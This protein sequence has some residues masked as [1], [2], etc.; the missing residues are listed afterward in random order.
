MS[1]PVTGVLLFRAV[2]QLMEASILDS[3]TCVAWFLFRV[4]GYF[5]LLSP[6]VIFLVFNAPRF[7]PDIFRN[8]RKTISDE[9]GSKYP[10]AFSICTSFGRQALALHWDHTCSALSSRNICHPV[11]WGRMES[12]GRRKS[13]GI[14]QPWW[15][16]WGWVGKQPLAPHPRALHCNLEFRFAV[17]TTCCQ[18]SPLPSRFCPL[19]VS[20]F[21]SQF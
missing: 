16:P 9:E 11:L 3:M 6:S 5:F 4:L 15:H 10:W 2:L 17:L 8:M 12:P 18:G 19:K 14:L 21:L 7:N 1:L 13:Q 20:H